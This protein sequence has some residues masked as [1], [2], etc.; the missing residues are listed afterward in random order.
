MTKRSRELRAV[1]FDSSSPFTT[2]CNREDKTESARETEVL[3]V[4]G[5]FNFQKWYTNNPLVYKP[6]F[7]SKYFS[8]NGRWFHW[9]TTQR[10][11]PCGN[12]YD[13]VVVIRCLGRS[14][15]HIKDLL[16]SVKNF[17]LMQENKTTE[18]YRSSANNSSTG[19]SQWIRQSVRPSR[20][21]R[22]VS[23]DQQQKTQIVNDINEYLQPATAH[24]Y[25]EQGI[26]YRRGYLFHGP[27]GT[28]KTSLSFALA[29]VFGLS[30]Y[31]VSLGEKGLAESDLAMLFDNLPQR[32]IVL[33]EDIDTAGV[34]RESD[35]MLISV[36]GEEA[37]SGL[38]EDT[39]S[40]TMINGHIKPFERVKGRVV[41]Q[42]NPRS[43]S[44]SLIS[45]AGLLN[46]IDG[47]ASQEVSLR[48]I[49]IY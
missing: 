41:G 10:A 24:W 30:I 33:L 3:S 12:G 40:P 18:V 13:R 27:P 4:N 21:M 35:N 49:S 14:T 26:P 15:E 17:A 20:P 34:R 39:I 19:G 9:S 5:L 36:P 7:S 23:L 31:C 28:G 42:I 1:T 8:H 38:A 16:C 48:V 2:L 43:K 46:I 44:R 6:N 22:T 32:C 29:G 25:A 45:L 11:N 47:A 37:S